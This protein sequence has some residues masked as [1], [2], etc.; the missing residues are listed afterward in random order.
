MHNNELVLIAFGLIYSAAYNKAAE[1]TLKQRET[2]N[3]EIIMTWLY[4]YNE[5]IIKKI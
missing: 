4:I 3:M 5:V 1:L 2:R